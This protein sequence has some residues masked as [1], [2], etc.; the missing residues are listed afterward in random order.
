[1]DDAIFPH[2]RARRHP[3]PMLI[4]DIR[5]TRC[6]L[7]PKDYHVG[8]RFYHDI[9]RD[10]DSLSAISTDY[11]SWYVSGKKRQNKTQFTVLNENDSDLEAC[12]SLGTIVIVNQFRAFKHPRLL[13]KGYDH[14]LM[15]IHLEETSKEEIRWVIENRGNRINRIN[16]YQTID[17][18]NML[19]KEWLAKEE[20]VIQEDKEYLNDFLDKILSDKIPL[21]WEIGMENQGG[22]L[23]PS[24]YLLQ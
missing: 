2:L 9:D 1:M 22:S 20:E 18:P 14:H 16:S 15:C 24:C 11:C 13:N 3:P 7:D 23:V 5:L 8:A 6:A 21:R 19:A 10:R 17:V 12:R 4:Q